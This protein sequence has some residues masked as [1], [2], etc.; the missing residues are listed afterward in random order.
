MGM[1]KNPFWKKSNVKAN[2]SLTKKSQSF[3]K[4]QMKGLGDKI[5][6]KSMD[7]MAWHSVPY[8]EVGKMYFFGYDPKHKKTLP[9][10]DRLPLVIPIKFYPDGFLGVNLHYLPTVAR[11][12]FLQQL[13]KIGGDPKMNDQ[14][15]L[16]LSYSLLN[17][18][19]KSSYF[20]PTIHRYLATHIVS[21]IK[22]V[23]P[24]DWEGVVFLPT[25]RWAKGKPY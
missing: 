17:G 16:K 15:K 23:H 13:I 11:F 20:Q 2:T 14:T 12:K 3:F 4:R 6:K 21:Q 24:D 18:V 25:A 9:M 8:V 10:Y 7:Q 19:A 5:K 1:F 22:I